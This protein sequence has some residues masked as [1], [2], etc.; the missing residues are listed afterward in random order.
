MVR[1]IIA[2]DLQEWV[3]LMAWI[4][5]FGFWIL[6]FGLGVCPSTVTSYLGDKKAKAVPDVCSVPSMM[7]FGRLCSTWKFRRQLLKLT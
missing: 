1:T 4:L 3:V 7:A 5:D 6:D 2:A